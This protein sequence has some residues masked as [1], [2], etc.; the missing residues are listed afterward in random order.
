MTLAPTTEAP[1]HPRQVAPTA[2]IRGS[3]DVPG[4]KSLSHRAAIFNAVADGPSTITGFSS[5]ADCATTLACLRQLGVEVEHTGS[6]VRVHGVGLRGLREPEDVLDCGNSGTTTR[7]LCGLLAGAD[8]FV[9]LT[10]DAS[11]RR[12]PMAR[13]AAPLAEMGAR[14][15]GRQGN[16]LL[17]IAIAPSGPL[18]AREH[19]TPVASAQLK[20]ALILAG[21]RAD[22][23][24]VVIEPSASRDHTERMLRSMGANVESQGTRIIVHP[25]SHLRPVDVA[26][27]GDFSSA[28]FWLVLGCLHPDA[29]VRVLNVGINPTRTGLLTILERMGASLTRE[30]QREE[31]GEPVADL[32]ARSSRLHGMEVG[33]DLIPLAIDEIPLV[34]LLGAFAAGET[35]VRDATELRAKE[36]D[37][38]AVVADG[39]AALGV[40]IQVTDDGW[41]IRSSQLRAGNVHSA[42]DHRM[43]MLFA[44]AGTLGQGATIADAEAVGISYPTF[45]QDLARLAQP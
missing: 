15:T 20:S 24:S 26:I 39:L 11:L 38:L 27:P 28:A 30:N 25:A 8:V 21:L 4:D 37:R 10:G 23:P 31:A 41:R 2:R 34:A 3:L 16:R 18:H 33:G 22:T 5:G 42:G 9:V 7:L 35:V 36:S 29:E 12:R 44:L 6:T 32:V 13:V 40:A 19:R 14:F 1:A 17:P 45:W 43:A